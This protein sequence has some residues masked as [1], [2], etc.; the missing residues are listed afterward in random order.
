MMIP[1][2]FPVTPVKTGAQGNRQ[3]LATRKCRDARYMLHGAL[4]PRFRGDDNG[5]SGDEGKGA[6]V[7]RKRSGGDKEKGAR[8]TRGREQGWQCIERE[9]TKEEKQ[10]FIKVHWINLSIGGYCFL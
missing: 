3:D 2:F 5:G 1:P 10:V 4:G 6:G 9:M 8:V 7:T